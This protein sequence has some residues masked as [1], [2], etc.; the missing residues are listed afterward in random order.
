MVLNIQH[1]NK[2]QKMTSM[3]TP[4]LSCLN[5]V[6]RDNVTTRPVATNLPAVIL[7]EYIGDRS[8]ST[9]NIAAAQMTG[10][11]K[12]I[13]DRREDALTTGAVCFVSITTFDDESTTYTSE[14]SETSD[15]YANI[16][17]VPKVL[18]VQSML[19]PR[20]CTRLIDT[21]YERASAFET[22]MTEIQD[23]LKGKDNEKLVAVFALSTDGM[24]NA[25]NQHRIQDLNAIITRLRKRGA[26]MM[27]LAANQDAIATGNTFGFAE[28][29]A[30]TFGATPETA[31]AAYQGM[32]QLARDSSEGLQS[33]GFS[34]S[35]RQCSAPAHQTYGQSRFQPRM[36]SSLRM[37]TCMPQPDF[38]IGG[39]AGSVVNDQDPSDLTSGNVTPP[40]LSQVMWAPVVTFGN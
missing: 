11:Q 10:L 15:E 13:D 26:Q 29:H 19:E 38:P 3:T 28:S 40:T 8:G 31:K 4:T 18:N 22:K 24:D 9:C 25:S 33:P 17:N 37:T 2:K 5:S 39:A 14:W 21:A 27:F 1:K 23:S 32:S 30:M 16:K 36:P 20:G 7:F 6:K 34:Q 35:M 12:C